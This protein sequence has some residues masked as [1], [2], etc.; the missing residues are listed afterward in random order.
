MYNAM[1]DLIGVG[2]MPL[3]GLLEN[4]AVLGGLCR[5][6]P[7]ERPASGANGDPEGS[8][9]AGAQATRRRPNRRRGA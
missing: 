3:Q 2:T 9:G 1:A 7:L 4:A 8:S 6:W 5:S